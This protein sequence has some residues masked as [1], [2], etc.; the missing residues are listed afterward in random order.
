M[1]TKSKLIIST[2]LGLIKVSSVFGQGYFKD[3]RLADGQDGPHQGR[4]EIL[5]YDDKTKKDVWGSVC[6]DNFSEDEANVFC[7]MLGYSK[8]LSYANS[9]RMGSMAYSRYMVQPDFDEGNLVI[10][11]QILYSRAL[12]T[13]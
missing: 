3:L 2:T 13:F 9:G 10:Y 11:G 7:K 5:R 1:F 6:D 12:E 8:A 4:I